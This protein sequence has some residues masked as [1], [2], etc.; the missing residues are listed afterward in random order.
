MFEKLEP[1]QRHSCASQKGQFIMAKLSDNSTLSAW[2]RPIGSFRAADTSARV[3][4]TVMTAMLCALAYIAMVLIHLKLMPAAPFL[5]YDPKDAVIVM[6]GFLF[7]PA[8]A[9]IISVIVSFLEMITVSESGI[10]GFIMQ[11]VATL[12]YAGV[13][14]AVYRR[15]LTKGGAVAGLVLGSL[16]MVIVMVLWNYI[17]SPIYLGTDRS[18]VVALLVPA[19][20]PFNLVKA[21]LNSAIAFV[22][23]KPLVGALRRSGLVAERGQN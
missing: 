7:G 6:G 3:K 9:I 14:S 1:L 18:A 5:T 20:I 22:L 10:I 16:C 2:E 21:A 4:R 15:H 19:I 11:V 12:A 13:A 23:Y 17:L 8:T